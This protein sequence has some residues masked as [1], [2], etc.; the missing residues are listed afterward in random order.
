MRM[1][2]SGLEGKE[3]SRGSTIEKGVVCN[4]KEMLDWNVISC[5]EGMIARRVRNKTA[6]SWK[7]KDFCRADRARF[8]IRRFSLDSSKRVSISSQA[9]TKSEPESSILMTCSNTWFVRAICYLQIR[10][11]PEEFSTKAGSTFKTVLVNR[12]SLRSCSKRFKSNL[13]AK[14]FSS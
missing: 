6:R 12:L 9:T 4:M 10:N 2:G 8:K 5:F 14:P 3:G 1:R 13:E 11:L 7:E